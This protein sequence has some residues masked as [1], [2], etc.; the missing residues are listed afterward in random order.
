MADSSATSHSSVAANAITGS[1][2]ICGRGTSPHVPMI[3]LL[4]FCLSF[5]S[6]L[7]HMLQRGKCSLISI[8]IPFLWYMVPSLN[9]RW[10]HDVFRN[11]R[12]DPVNGVLDLT[13]EVAGTLGDLEHLRPLLTYIDARGRHGRGR[14]R[15][16]TWTW[17]WTDTMDVDVDVD[18]G[19]GRGRGLTPRTWTG[20][21]PT[22]WTWTWMDAVDVDVDGRSGCG[23][24]CWTP[25][26][27]TW[28][29]AMDVDG[30]P[31]AQA[32]R[33]YG[34]RLGSQAATRRDRYC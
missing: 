20:R 13:D 12:S 8:F 10:H 11:D 21:G 2:F 4:P 22:P 14:G 28:M 17:T 29:D 33:P 25:W 26:M 31:M 9:F 32:L 30:T 15:R 7:F 5:F 34:A 18:G 19:R 23:R 1:F 27:W 6:H 3:F 16:R 24:G